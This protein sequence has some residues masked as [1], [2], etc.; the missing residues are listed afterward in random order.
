M[1][2]SKRWLLRVQNLQSRAKDL[3]CR[4]LCSAGFEKSTAG[5]DRLLFLVAFL[6]PVMTARLWAT[7]LTGLTLPDGLTFRL[8][9]RQTWGLVRLG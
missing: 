2:A 8:T 7:L 4:S 5:W 9:F 1:S 6:A 3:R